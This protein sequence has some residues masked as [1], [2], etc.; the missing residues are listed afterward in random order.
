MPRPDAYV[1]LAETSR[2]GRPESI[3]FG[4]VVALNRDG[5]IAFIA[6]DPHVTIYPRS[7]NKPMQASVMVQ[8]GLCLPP[9]LLAL[10]CG[11]HDGTPMHL[12]IARRILA[13]VSLDESV[14]RNTP[15]LPLDEASAD[16][17]IRSGGWRTSLQQNC[18][19]KHGA[20]IATCAING[21]PL[22]SYLNPDH[23]LQDAITV[24]LPDMIGEP[25]AHVGVDGC[26]APAHMMSLLGLARA[27]RVMA[28]SDDDAPRQVYAAMTRHPETV[29]GARRD[30]TALM[31]HVPGLMAKDGADG[32]FAVALADGRAV[33]LKVADGAN[34]ARPPAMV[35]AL[36]ALDVDVDAVAPIV[37]QRILGHGHE[38]GEVTA[39]AEYV[40]AATDG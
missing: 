7:S 32:V 3:H 19:G 13:T 2:S 23:P 4:A 17:V 21:W 29:G 25:V 35:H 8:L 16:E 40:V 33:A 34:R 15:D 14:L 1:P 12:D 11:S 6:G 36:R 38:V 27:F 24:G 22:D 37:R 31:Q 26:G 18:S 30:V 39:I 5:G 20:M 10:V 28:T 9:E